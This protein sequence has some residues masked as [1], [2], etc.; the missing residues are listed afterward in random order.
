MD[1]VHLFS[2]SGNRQLNKE[3]RI[4]ILILSEIR[5]LREGLAQVLERDIKLKIVGLAADEHSARTLSTQLDPDVI[6]LD[7]AF[8]N[9]SD[10]ARRFVSTV[11]NPRVIAFAVTEVE[12]DILSWAEAG[13]AG[14]IPKTA[15]LDD[16]ICLIHKIIRGEQMCSSRVAASLLRRLGSLANTIDGSICTISVA[17]SLTPREVQILQLINIGMSNK[18]ISRRLGIG[19]ATTKS[20]VHNLLKKLNLQGRNQAAV[21]ARS[22]EAHLRLY[23]SP[24][25]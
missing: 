12:D 5:F 3:T 18:E 8:P 13:V 7:A 20:H 4:G 15:A 9:G 10:I 21:W 22:N 19:V 6:L 2:R 11:S 17:S 14:Y 25:T 16:L 24:E 1:D 23:M